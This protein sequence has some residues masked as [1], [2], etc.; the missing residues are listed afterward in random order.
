MKKITRQIL[1]FAIAAVFFMNAA[2]I[3]AATFLFQPTTTEVASDNTFEVGIDVD[4]GTE[5]IAG[6]DIYLDYDTSYLEFQTVADGEYFPQVEDVPSAGRIYISGFVNTQGDYK[7]GSGRI[8]T[9]TFK[10]L[11]EGTTTLS[12]DCDPAQTDTSK[13]VQNDTAVTNILEC[14]TLQTHTVTITASATGGSTTTSEVTELPQSG[15][16]EDM[17]SYAVW[18]GVL[19]GTGALLRILLRVM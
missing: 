17:I 8:A 13:I 7:T 1:A 5:Q 18:G 2:S 15:V 19:V 9:V 6:T 12:I 14:G 4:A 11:Q 3:Y 10:A 16:V